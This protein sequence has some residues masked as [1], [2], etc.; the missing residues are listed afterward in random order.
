MYSLKLESLNKGQ[1]LEVAAP[2][3]PPFVKT[4][5]E[6]ESHSILLFPYSTEDGSGATLHISPYWDTN[7]F[8]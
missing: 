7:N 5:C 2:W 1:T 3:G 6:K 8:L 4:K